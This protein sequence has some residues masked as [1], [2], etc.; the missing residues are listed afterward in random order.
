M[1]QRDTRIRKH[2][3][4]IRFTV[5]GLYFAAICIRRNDCSDWYTTISDE[6]SDDVPIGDFAD[7]SDIRRYGSQIQVVTSWAILK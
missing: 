6:P 4:V 3:A 7:W 1:T 5:S 2:R